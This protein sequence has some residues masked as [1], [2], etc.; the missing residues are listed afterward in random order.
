MADVD[1][2]EGAG[3]QL[4][5]K[6]L[7]ALQF[8]GK[9]E[10]QSVIEN[11]KK[12]SMTAEQKLQKLKEKSRKQRQKGGNKDIRDELEKEQKQ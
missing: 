8:R 1:A 9:P 10:K 5:K 2:K 4:T 12:N 7:K 11:R 3:M 6:Q